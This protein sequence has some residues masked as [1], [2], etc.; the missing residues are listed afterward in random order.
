MATKMTV[1]GNTA[2]GHVAYA[3][4]DVAAIYP[5]TLSSPMAEVVDEWSAKGTKN[6]FGQTVHVS[7]MQSEAV[8]ALSMRTFTPAEW[9]AQG[10]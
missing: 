6:L 10:K 5:I 9:A 3:F 7:E 2:V 1:D 8:H 4:S